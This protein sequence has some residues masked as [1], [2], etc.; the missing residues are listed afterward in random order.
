ML[1]LVA[2]DGSDGSRAALRWVRGFADVMDATISVVQA[3]EYPSTAVL[4]GGPTLLP[5][6]EASKAVAAELTQVLRE[7][8]GRPPEGIETFVEPGTPDLAVLRVAARNGADLIVVGKRGLGAVASR[9][10]GSVSRR[11]VEHSTCPVAVVPDTFVQRQGPVVVGVDESADSGAAVQWATT[12]AA[13]HRCPL[14]VV[15]AVSAAPPDYPDSLGEAMDRAGQAI[16]DEQSRPAIDA[17]LEV[18]TVVRTMDPRTL[19]T[20][21]AGELDARLVV[22]GSRGAGPIAS[23]LMGSTATYLA[24]RS[25]GPVVLVPS[26][27]GDAGPASTE[28]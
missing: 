22:A 16:A 27:E 18:R 17:G 5:P 19:I 23:L 26:R 20:S 3:W 13:A 24:E 2:V 12:V 10:L 21:T 28:T 15:H 11:L 6:A 1:I 7:E 4:P 14:V 9:L 25:D 8:L